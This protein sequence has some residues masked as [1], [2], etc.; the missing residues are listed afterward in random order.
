MLDVI[1][2]R[3]IYVG[4][5]F[6]VVLF[7]LFTIIFKDS[8]LGIDMTGGTQSEFSYTGNI[9]LESLQTNLGNLKDD[10]NKSNNNIINAISIYSV[11]GEE[12]I[13]VET[14]F[15][16]IDDEKTLEN[17]KVTFN[18]L[19]LE[20][21]TKN[22]SSFSLSKYINIGKS[23]GDYIKKT[24]WL[25]LGIT[26]IAISLYIA[27]TFFGVAIGIPSS[28]F[29]IVAL[30]TL[31]HD[32]IVASGFYIFTGIFFPEFKVDTFFITALLTILGYSIND[33]IVVFD[34][35]RDNIKHYVKSKKL[36]EL[37]NMSINETLARSLFTSL[38]LFFVL[39]T[40]FFFG[41]E[42]LKGFMLTLIYGVAFG[43]YSSIFVAA[44]LLY[45]FNKSKTLKVYEKKII[46]DEDKIIV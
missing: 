29:A 32:V 3:Y 33:T 8:N 5:S 18:G 1:K 24:A 30:I 28:S 35:I 23:F 27:F 38:T 22:N 19:I 10:F 13:V 26:L 25:T 16:V 21:L 46:K 39:L 37:I 2:N 4:T 42:T 20:T 40:I 36:D 45:E 41:P 34:R 31:F 7:A 43:T 12:K 17:N 44:P 14:G 15:G 6:L 11:S 9:N